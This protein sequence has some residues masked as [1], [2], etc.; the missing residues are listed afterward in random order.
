MA[1]GWW[2]ENATLHQKL[3]KFLPHAR[4]D[5][6]L[7]KIVRCSKGGSPTH[8]G[9]SWRQPVLASGIDAKHDAETVAMWRGA[10]KQKQ[11]QRTD[12]VDNINDVNPSKGTSLANTVSRLQRESPTLF[13]QVVAPKRRSKDRQPAQAQTHLILPYGFPSL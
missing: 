7:Q 4:R 8:V 11:G 2:P 9:D 5:D 10:M 13:A 1:A 6:I 12:I 3:W